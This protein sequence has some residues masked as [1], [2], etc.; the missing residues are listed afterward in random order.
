MAF[1]SIVFI[2]AA[3]CVWRVYVYNILFSTRPRAHTHTPK[4]ARIRGIARNVLHASSSWFLSEFKLQRKSARVRARVCVCVFCYGGAANV[5]ASM[6]RWRRPLLW[7][8]T[9][10]HIV[11]IRFVKY[12]VYACVCMRIWCQLCFKAHMHTPK[13]KHN[14]LAFSAQFV[15][16]STCFLCDPN[17]RRVSIIV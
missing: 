10:S 6:R 5:F 13:Q 9:R 17:V 4:S 12:S 2:T 3:L 11:E 8:R 14:L 16:A 1:R 15:C 7:R